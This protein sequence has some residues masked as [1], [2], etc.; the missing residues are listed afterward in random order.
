MT[1]TMMQ[2]PNSINL[3]S[4]D[5]WLTSSGSAPTT[6]ELMAKTHVARSNFFPITIRLNN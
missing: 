6:S 3:K 2:K 5:D 1:D 4:F